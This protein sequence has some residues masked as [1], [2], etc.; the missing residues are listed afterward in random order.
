MM[1]QANHFVHY[2]PEKIPYAADRECGSNFE[3]REGADALMIHRLCQR[4]QEV[5]GRA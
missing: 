4:V 1:G 3:D 5:M 2:A